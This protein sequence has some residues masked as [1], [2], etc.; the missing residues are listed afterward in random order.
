MDQEQ[1]EWLKLALK[2]CYDLFESLTEG[3]EEDGY[4]MERFKLLGDTL[5]LLGIDLS[6]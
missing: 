3:K 2:F 4:Y 6:K 5:D 1:E